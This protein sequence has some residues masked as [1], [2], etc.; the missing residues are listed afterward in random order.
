MAPA[1]IAR[2]RNWAAGAGLLLGLAGVLGYFVIVFR[3]AAAMPGLRN[4]A[5][6]D[7][8]LIAGGLG[9]SAVALRRTFARPAEF[10]GRRS[11]LGLATAN[12]ALAGA[13]AWLLYGMT[14][15]PHA[16]GP[17]VGV[18]APDFALVDQEGHAVRL[19]DFRGAPLLLVFYRG[20]W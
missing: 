8:L 12:V 15:V 1:T 16:D 7:W 17:A 9:L 2:R 6:L 4:T 11:A 3:F 13:F 18:A 20:H 14:A 19:A 5:W 10:P